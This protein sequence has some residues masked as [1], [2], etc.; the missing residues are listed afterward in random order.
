MPVTVYSRPPR[1]VSAYKPNEWTFKSDRSPN[2]TP[3]ESTGIGLILIAN[4]AAVDLI[5]G[6]A[7]GDVYVTH[8][9][10]T[11]GTWVRGQQI[12]IAGTQVEHYNGLWR[13]VSTPN[14]T[15][16]VIDAPADELVI[17]S[18]FGTI[19]KIYERYR[20][21]V[22]V[23]FDTQ[24]D[25][26]RYYLDPGADG[27]FR[28][29]VRNQAQREFG[30]ND[31]FDIATEGIT[32]DMI[33]ADWRITNKYK[34]D[35]GEAYNIPN[36]DTG[37]NTYTVIFK[38]VATPIGNKDSIVVNSVQPYAHVNDWDGTVDLNWNDELESYEVN[39]TDT[40]TVK[41]LLTYFPGHVSGAANIPTQT[42][43]TADTAFLAFISWSINPQ[44]W[45]V[46][47]SQ[48]RE[49]GTT[50]TTVYNFTVAANSFI[51]PIGPG[52]VSIGSTTVYYDVSL[53]NE[54]GTEVSQRY[55]Y[56][57]DRTCHQ[58]PVRV[59]ALN[60]FGALDSFTF[61]GYDK[62]RT[63]MDRDIVSKPTMAPT[64]GAGGDYQRKAWRVRPDRGHT[65][66][67]ETLTKPMYRW[68]VDE[69]LESTDI[70][71]VV[72][73]GIWTPIFNKTDDVDMGFR[74]GRITF[75]YAYGVDN[76]VQTR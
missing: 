11:L 69:I 16:T 9:A 67:S 54:A 12:E 36:A 72:Q 53:T 48:M 23:T 17:G 25:A 75:D 68:V 41:R 51:I 64:I 56:T 62:R 65:T 52:N 35:I 73:G 44:T 57:M 28:M 74:S 7:L 55:R 29:D 3:G 49:N 31:I 60:K 71:T 34:L 43:G 5:P 6:L 24:T 20:V 22:D 76:M 33:A 32:L 13:V 26:Q 27:L 37:V 8:P 42:V 50:S 21:V 39:Q 61:I 59:W 70:R 47:V 58:S 38:D 66:E 4:Q 45:G 10:I 19:T 30:K 1:I 2:N 63:S 40:V 46:R 15:I 18:V 14:N